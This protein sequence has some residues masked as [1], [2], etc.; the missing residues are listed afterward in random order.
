MILRGECLAC[1]RLG[2]CTKT[3]VELVLQSYTCASFEPTPEPVYVARWD[4]MQQFGPQ[5][6]V[7][8]MLLQQKPEQEE[9]KTQ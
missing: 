5:S 7:E 2:E 9:E 8:A 3:N 1:D 6:A 4:L